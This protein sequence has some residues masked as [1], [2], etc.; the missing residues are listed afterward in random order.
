VQ[1]TFYRLLVSLVLLCNNTVLQASTL[2]YSIEGVGGELRKNIKAW[3]G[4]DPATPEERAN[5]VASAEERAISSLQALGYY[6]SEI[7]LQLDKSAPQWQMTIAV[8][9]GEPVVISSV[10]VKLS[11]EAS[12]D[13]AFVRLLE[14]N[15]LAR[16]EIFN[17]GDYEAF[18]RQLLALGQRRGYFEGEASLAR[19]EVN[20][21]A[22]SADIA[23]HYDSGA[24]YRFGELELDETIGEMNWVWQMVDF[25]AG[26]PFDLEKLQKLRS[27]LQ[28]TGFFSSVLVLPQL[29]ALADGR[30]PIKVSVT[31][32]MRHSFD[33]GVGYSTDTEERVS[34]TW[35]TPL[36]NRYGH[37]QETRLE[38]SSINPSG[39]FTYNIPLS[40]P[41]NDVLQLSAYLEDNVF[42]DLD[43]KQKG[44]RVRRELKKGRW[45]AS[46]SLRTLDE[47]WELGPEHRNNAY[48][49]PG[50]SLSHKI[51]SGSLIDPSSGFHQVYLVEGGAQDLG[52]DIDL[53]RI[54]SNFRLVTSLSERH[55][56]VARAELGAVFVSDDDRKDLAP[57]LSFFAGGSQSLRG[58]AY[59]SIGD[60]VV[61]EAA[62]GTARTLVVGGNRLATVSVEYQYYF[63]ENW[64]GALFTD[65]G[66]AFS[67][68][69]FELNYS[70]GLGAHYMSPVGAIRIEVANSLS[71]DHPSWRLHL[72]IGAEF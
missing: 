72:N 59:Q 46:Y 13:Q 8:T 18:K 2:E 68:G 37:S 40:H 45:I 29:E 7:Q 61:V 69:N 30:V 48:T 60:E 43:S 67:T 36:L 3:L 28:Q 21:S 70:A 6:R 26:D 17:H 27:E 9:A 66:D 22:Q 34:V 25:Q 32:S 4:S 1:A 12:T 10:D 5:F 20:A 24:R 49:L 47:S 41:L 42:G 54:Y 11:G 35:R 52:S 31:I 44:V 58:F 15:P 65:A 38:Y 14:E 71:E 39:R 23:L 51:R 19:V 33:F 62:D 53:F 55:R 64:R 56:L 57:S 63:S 50:A 16:G